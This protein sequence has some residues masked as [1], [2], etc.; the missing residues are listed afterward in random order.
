LGIRPEDIEDSEFTLKTPSSSTI[1]A[2]VKVR[3]NHGADIFLSTLIGNTTLQARVTTGTSAQVGK[4]IE[5]VLNFAKVHIFDGE[6]EMN[7]IV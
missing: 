7:L 1:T 2:E 4:T 6:T 3:E 5:L